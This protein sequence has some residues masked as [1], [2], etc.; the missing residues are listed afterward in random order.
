MLN[1]ARD[2][3]AP[4]GLSRRA[5]LKRGAVVGAAAVWTV[6]VI[7]AVSMTPAHADSPSAPVG[8][9]PG[10]GGG[11][12]PIDTGTPTPTSGIEP[13]QAQRT[14]TPPAT[15]TTSVTDPG[16][17]TPTLGVS[18]ISAVREPSLGIAGVHTSRNLANTGT[19]TPIGPTLAVGAA[20]VAL[21]M[22]TLVAARRRTAVEG[23]GDSA[24][25]DPGDVSS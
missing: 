3:T 11:V 6:P 14:P 25:A 9:P 2:S 19:D 4:A 16:D 5:L 15:P 18:G 1:D 23:P 8:P 13:T 10:G 22:G 12:T 17:Q 7:S 20:A 21:G 24:E